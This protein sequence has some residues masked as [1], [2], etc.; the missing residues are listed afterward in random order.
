M[1]RRKG[2]RRRRRRGRGW[3]KRRGER[4]HEDA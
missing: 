1:K 3:T 2:K 4:R